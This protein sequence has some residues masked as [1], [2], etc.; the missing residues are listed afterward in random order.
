MASPDS[1]EVP[2]GRKNGW[3]R[4]I[5]VSAASIPLWRSWS[6]NKGPPLSWED[7]ARIT[8]GST[9]SPARPSANTHVRTRCS[10]LPISTR[11]IGA[12]HQ[13]DED[14]LQALLFRDQR[15]HG[16]PA[17]NHGRV[18]PRGCGR[19]R[20]LDLEHSPQLPV[21]RV[22]VGARDGSHD[23]PGLRLVIPLDPQAVR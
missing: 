9:A 12:L 5:T 22:E 3:M 18:H 15:A 1:S 7:V 20:Q 6:K 2:R 19:G 13:L 21:G 17:S 11:N 23:L 4:T 10:D 8:T 16:D 14:V